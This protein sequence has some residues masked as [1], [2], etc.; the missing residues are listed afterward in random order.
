MTLRIQHFRRIADQIERESRNM[1]DSFR[2]AEAAVKM[3][4][5]QMRPTLFLKHIATGKPQI[6]LDFN[7]PC[8]A[9]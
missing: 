5:A 2:V 9:V 8:T 6:R 7:D 1:A 3:R 4:S